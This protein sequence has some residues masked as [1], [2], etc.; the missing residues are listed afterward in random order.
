MCP[1]LSFILDIKDI[2]YSHVTVSSRKRFHETPVSGSVRII[3]Q[4]LDNC[5]LSV[6]ASRGQRFDPQFHGKFSL[7]QRQ[8]KELLMAVLTIR[9]LFVGLSFLRRVK[10]HKP[11]VGACDMD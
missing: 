5:L 2:E 10:P 6:A 8:C 1:S 7:R 11:F 3:L 4:S 9:E